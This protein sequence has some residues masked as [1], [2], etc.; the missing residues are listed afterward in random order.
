LS[1][2]TFLH[3]E[4]AFRNCHTIKVFHTILKEVDIRFFSSVFILRL[5]SVPDCFNLFQLLFFTRDEEKLS[6]EQKNLLTFQPI[7]SG[8][9]FLQYMEF[10]F[11]VSVLLVKLALVAVKLLTLE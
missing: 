10:I 1:H 11:K 3:N 8:I 2:C 5:S 4:V 6:M 9:F 7:F